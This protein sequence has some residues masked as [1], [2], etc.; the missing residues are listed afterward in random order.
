MH[1]SAT[2]IASIKSKT[3]DLPR[4]FAHCF[5]WPLRDVQIKYNIVI[6]AFVIF[7]GDSP[8]LDESFSSRVINTLRYTFCRPRLHRRG[9][10]ATIFRLRSATLRDSRSES[11]TGRAIYR[12]ANISPKKERSTASTSSCPA[13]FVAFPRIISWHLSFKA[14]LVN[15]KYGGQYRMY[16]KAYTI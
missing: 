1:T 3:K 6:K 2:L 13:F 4:I 14:A 15:S 8:Q 11:R 16:L 7:Q 10:V 9:I 5:A 12:Y